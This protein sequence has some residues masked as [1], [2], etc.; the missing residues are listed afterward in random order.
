MGTE[1]ADNRPE[2]GS[3]VMNVW[4]GDWLQS[5]SCI[6]RPGS[7]CPPG[8]SRQC[9]V[10]PEIRDSKCWNEALGSQAQRV[11]LMLTLQSHKARRRTEAGWSAPSP[12]LCADLPD[13]QPSTQGEGCSVSREAVPHELEVEAAGLIR[14]ALTGDAFAIDRIVTHVHD[15]LG[16]RLFATMAPAQP[17]RCWTGARFAVCL[18]ADS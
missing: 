3:V 16:W 7:T 15:D 8:T 12:K 6:Q 5:N 14:A 1:G 11:L 4:A 9:P 2:L 17:P 18:V 10:V 13:Q